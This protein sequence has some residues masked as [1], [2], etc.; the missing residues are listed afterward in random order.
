MGKINNEIQDLENGFIPDS[1][2]FSLEGYMEK[3]SIMDDIT[4]KTIDLNYYVDKLDP[5][6]I[7]MYPCLMTLVQEEYEK[8]KH[9]TPLE[10]MEKLQ[11]I[12]T[13][14]ILNS[15]YVQHTESETDGQQN[16][17]DEVESTGESTG[18]DSL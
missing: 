13:P 12:K 15:E 16:T 11:Q 17:A 10:E 14:L 6:L 1:M 7:G 18:S 5:I 8:N 4:Y 9:R 2:D 3:Q